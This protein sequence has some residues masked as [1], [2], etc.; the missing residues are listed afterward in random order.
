[1]VAMLSNNDWQMFREMSRFPQM[2]KLTLILLLAF[3]LPVVA[4][5]DKP[6]VIDATNI[7]LL[8]QKVGGVV[9]VEG[10][11]TTVGSTK[12]KSITFINVGLSKKQGFA[13][14]IF[15]KN[16]GAFPSG[17]DAFHDQKV[18]VTGPLQLYQGNNPQI[19]VKTADQIEII[20]A[21]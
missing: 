15:E 6:E 17:F 12:N 2:Q 21:E 8:R 16:Y 9:T 13:A 7:D 5:E 10:S 11:V 19:E 18:R 3:I 14:V 1:M 4:Q 20:K